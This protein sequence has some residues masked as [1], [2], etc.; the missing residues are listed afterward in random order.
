MLLLTVSSYS[1]NISGAVSDL[2]SEQEA[3]TS[4]AKDINI[5]QHKYG[6]VPN[7]AIKMETLFQPFIQKIY[8]TIDLGLP[9]AGHLKT[10]DVVTF[11]EFVLEMGN[12]VVDVIME[13]LG[14]KLS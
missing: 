2:N 1:K 4:T 8:D 14:R 3:S 5:V 10:G 11:G 7:A 9:Y 12:M 13:N 6:L